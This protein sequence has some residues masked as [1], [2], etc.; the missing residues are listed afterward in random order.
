VVDPTVRRG[1]ITQPFAMINRL[2][3]NNA[4]LRMGESL[5]SAGPNNNESNTFGLSLVVQMFAGKA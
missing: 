3:S 2:A 4:N 1:D 5:S